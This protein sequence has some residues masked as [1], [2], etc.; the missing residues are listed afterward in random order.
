MAVITRTTAWVW[1]SVI[2]K[3]AP[4]LAG[5]GDDVVAVVGLVRAHDYE[6]G[7]AGPS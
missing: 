4:A 3:C 5:V 7:G 1:R 2:E 6:S